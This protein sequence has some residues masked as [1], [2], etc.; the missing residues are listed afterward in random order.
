LCIEHNTLCH[1]EV[2]AILRGELAGVQA[3][4]PGSK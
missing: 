1:R 3:V 4:K 2:G